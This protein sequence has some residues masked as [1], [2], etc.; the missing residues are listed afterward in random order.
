MTTAPP[1]RAPM[2][3]TYSP[4]VQ[5]AIHE[6]SSRPRCYLAALPWVE[7]TELPKPRILR[8]MTARPACR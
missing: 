5:N 7:D 6:G 1:T 4:I 3:T 8:D 2:R